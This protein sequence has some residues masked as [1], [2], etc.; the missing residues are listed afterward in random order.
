MFAKLETLKNV[1]STAINFFIQIPI[2]RDVLFLFR[3]SLI[4]VL[5]NNE[6]K[7]GHDFLIRI[8]HLK[9]NERLEYKLIS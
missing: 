6:K 7:I 2:E 1:K 5:C 8:N 3:Q 9:A 4:K